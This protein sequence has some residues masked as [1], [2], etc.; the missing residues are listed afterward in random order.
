MTTSAGGPNV[1]AVES[2]ASDRPP[3]QVAQILLSEIEGDVGARSLTQSERFRG[4]LGIVF[5]LLIVAM[6][7]LSLVF[8]TIIA[9]TSRPAVADFARPAFGEKGADAYGQAR[10]LWFS[11]VKDLLQ[12]LVVALLVPMLSTLIGFLFARKDE[13]S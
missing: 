12:L 3:A 11:N 2:N 5:A 9:L 1:P 7:V 6:F 13:V 10:I 4:Q 8:V